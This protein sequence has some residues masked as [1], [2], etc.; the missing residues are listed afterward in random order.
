MDDATWQPIPGYEGLYEVSDLGQIRSL[1][2]K[3]GNNRTYGG[4]ILK[5]LLRPPYLT[6]VLSR[7]GIE[8]RLRVHS[9]VALAFIGQRPAGQQVRHGPGGALDNRLV[10][11]CYGTPAEN[12][13]DKVRDGTVVLAGLAALNAAKTHCDHGHEFTE[14]NT[15][16]YY[17]TRNCR[18]CR[19]AYRRTAAGLAP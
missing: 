12:A 17:G 15:Y 2:R 7:D 5:P 3:G 13:A 1:P 6:V 4:K 9:L 16:L 10:N 19:R 8:A 18:T 11:L 14:A